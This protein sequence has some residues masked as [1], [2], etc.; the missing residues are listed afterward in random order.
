MTRAHISKPILDSAGNVR[1]GA[2]V[3]VLQPGI[4]TAYAGIL[5]AAN[6]GSATRTNP[7]IATNGVVDFYLDTPDRVRLGVTVGMEAEVFFEDVD[8][9]EPATPGGGTF[10]PSGTGTDSTAVSGVSTNTSVADA[11]G[12]RSTAYGTS[13][14]AP[15]TLSTALGSDTSAEATGAISV[16]V[17]QGALGSYDTLFG[18]ANATPAG[19]NSNLVAGRNSHAGSGTPIA[20]SI[21]LG[22]QAGAEADFA[23]AIGRQASAEA[24]R[25]IAIGKSAVA[26]AADTGI[27]QVDQLEVSSSSAAGA[28]TSLVLTDSAGARWKITVDTTGHLTTTAL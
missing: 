10:D 26:S 13:A 16:G 28:P 22:H 7:F 4:T 1:A 25:S 23:I 20:D 6:Q 19:G 11:S 5:Y 17:N 2:S 24:L 21:A 12:D 9:L 14:Y 27:I 8:V 3:R 15:A 18:Y